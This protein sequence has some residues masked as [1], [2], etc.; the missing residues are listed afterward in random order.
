MMQDIAK[1]LDLANHRADATEA[2]ILELCRK[3][4]ENDQEEM[5]FVNP[6]F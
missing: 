4:A 5:V 2:Q 1:C 3:V 6:L